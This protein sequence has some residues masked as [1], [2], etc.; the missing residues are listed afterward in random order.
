MNILAFY[1]VEIVKQDDQWK[2]K[3]RVYDV[4]YINFAAPEG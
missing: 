2:F 3:K 4:V 1:A